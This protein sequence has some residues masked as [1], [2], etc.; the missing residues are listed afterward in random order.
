[1]RYFRIHK[2]PLAWDIPGLSQ[3]SRDTKYSRIHRPP[4]MG[5]PGWSQESQETKYSR[6]HRLPWH[7]TSRDTA[8]LVHVLGI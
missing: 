7:G 6:I 3:E 5:H 8:G 2:L 1:V 4:G